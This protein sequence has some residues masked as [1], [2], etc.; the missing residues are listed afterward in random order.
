MSRAVVSTVF[1]VALALW[2]GAGVFFSGVVLPTLFLKLE[3]S[4][5]GQTAAL[6][7]PGYY[8]FGIGTG[9]VLLVAS[10]LLARGGQGAWKLAV[11]AVALA[12]DPRRE[13]ENPA[14]VLARRFHLG[15]EETQVVSLLLH[16]RDI[17]AI[18]GTLDVPRTAIAACLAN[19]YDQIGT[20]RQVE[21]VKLLLARGG[22]AV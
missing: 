2:T 15:Y 19:L 10:A 7:F 14:H 16:G 4:V 17:A 8:A 12:F 1:L 22:G 9:A 21:L 13:E 6:L 11:L 18:A 5:A 20:T 3:T